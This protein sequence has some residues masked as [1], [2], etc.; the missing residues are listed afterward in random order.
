M[1]APHRAS[2]TGVQRKDTMVAEMDFLRGQV[3]VVTGAS[4]GI[5]AATARALATAG[6]DV[7][8][9]ARRGDRLLAVAE[10]IRGMPGAGR[11]LPVVTDVTEEEQIVA[12]ADTV[13][14]ELGPIDI[15]VNNAGRGSVAAVHEI[16]ADE[17][18]RTMRVNFRGAVLCAK[19]MITDMTTRRRGAVVNIASVSAKRGWPAGTPYVASKFALRGFAQC[20]WAELRPHGVRVINLY[21]D[22]VR[23]EIFETMGV[24]L[25][26]IDRAMDPCSIAELVLTALRLPADT[27]VV[28]IEVC[29]VGMA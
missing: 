2:Y 27:N 18:D 29:P 23:T 8:L 19:H 22:Y 17:L 6:A 7:A 16:D 12:L 15:L 13:R 28:E 4:S 26:G 9:A 20:L 3:G 5:G 21:P 25:A 11:A 14:S 1:H 24:E 10:E